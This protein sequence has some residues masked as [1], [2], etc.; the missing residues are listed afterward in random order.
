MDLESS[1]IGY[2]TE[3]HVRTLGLLAPLVANSM[4]NARLYEDIAERE[5]R[6]AE[7]LRAAR[8]LQEALLLR[9]P[10]E[11][12][13][14]EVA[15]RSRAAQ[16]ISGDLYDFFEQAAGVDVIAFGDVS[17]KGAGASLYGA[18]VAGLLRTLAP[19][20]PTPGGLMKSLNAALGERKIHA[21]YVTLLV[22]FWQAEHRIF[23]ISNAGVFPPI[24]CRRGEILKQR[25][26]G[27]PLG[28][29]DERVY[30]EVMFRAEPDDVMLL[31][32]DGVHDQ[33]DGAGEEYGRSQL[34]RLL[35]ENWQRSPGEIADVVMEDLDRFRGRAEVTDDQTVLVFKV[36]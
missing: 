23:T 19:Q 20:R 2:F 31:Y 5:R 9:E 16:E 15:A 25:V 36:K 14:L 18:L 29:L 10:P 12:D 13:N 6:S 8:H 33:T 34:Y 11:L 1:R 4:E 22:L 27:I 26:E 3:D 30:D 28:L 7:N 17:G 21:T 24:L 35:A 32:S